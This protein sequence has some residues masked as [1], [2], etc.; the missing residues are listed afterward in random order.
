MLT[1]YTGFLSPNDAK[2]NG[3]QCNCL[4]TLLNDVPKAQRHIP[5]YHLLSVTI[6]TGQE[7]KRFRAKTR[8]CCLGIE[9]ITSLFTVRKFHNINR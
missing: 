6:I 1:T 9:N 7:T 8:R 5:Q 3:F 4:Y 2:L